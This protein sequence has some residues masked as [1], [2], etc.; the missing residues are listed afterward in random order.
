M[1][2]VNGAGIGGGG[3]VYQIIQGIETECNIS[4]NPEDTVS[5]A[6][7]GIGI[8]AVR[9]SNAWRE[10]KFFKR[11]VVPVAVAHQEDVA[12]HRR[13]ADG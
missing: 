8:D 3:G 10:I 7:H 13:C 4:G 6:H 5:T 2:P 12:F 9:Q 11:D 1:R